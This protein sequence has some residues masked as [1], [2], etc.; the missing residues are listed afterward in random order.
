MAIQAWACGCAPLSLPANPVEAWGR[1]L[2]GGIDGLSCTPSYLQM[3]MLCEPP[4]AAGWNPS[5]IAL[6]GEVLHP[7]AGV[8][9]GRRFPRATFTV[10]YA[11]AE[12]GLL[13]KTR[14]LDGWYELESLSRRREWRVV[15]GRL[16]IRSGAEWIALPDRIEIQGDLARVVGRLD[17][18]ANVGGAK[19]D[20]NEVAEAALGVAGVLRASPGREPDP[21]LGEIVVLRCE[22]E[23]GVSEGGI[24]PALEGAMRDRLPKPA[25]P[26]RWSFGP[27]QLGPNIKQTI[28]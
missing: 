23:P 22:L 26:R 10:V 17:Q 20:L 15:G 6:G 5:R 13:L 1:L 7:R 3:L 21:I 28:R 12:T 9:F 2:G 19:V 27:I 18:V 25:W 11:A 24:R 8:W 14:R 16:E 4:G